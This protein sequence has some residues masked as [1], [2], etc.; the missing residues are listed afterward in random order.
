MTIA[1]PEPIIEPILFRVAINQGIQM[2]V[3][4]IHPPEGPPVCTALKIASAADAAADVID[5]FQQFRAHRHFHQPVIDLAG[6]GEHF[7]AF[8]VC[9]P[10]ELYHSAPSR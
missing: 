5:D 9:V 4:L 3:L 6:Q 8:R 10:I 7:R 1:P 2:L